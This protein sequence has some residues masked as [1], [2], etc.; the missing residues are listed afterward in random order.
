MNGLFTSTDLCLGFPA[1]S[2]LL[3]AGFSQIKN[4]LLSPSLL[5]EF[6]HFVRT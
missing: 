6:V 5:K 2:D 4:I 3:L 1:D